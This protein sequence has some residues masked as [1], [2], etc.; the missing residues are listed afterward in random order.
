MAK[1]VHTK[2]GRKYIS[3]SNCRVE[4]LY[5]VPEDNMIN[6]KRVWTGQMYKIKPLSYQFP[7]TS[8]L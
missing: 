6:L 2:N 8:H 3:M 4:R 1:D 7:P 5:P